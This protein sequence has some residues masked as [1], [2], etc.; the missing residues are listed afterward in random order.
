M[1]VLHMTHPSASS[2]FWSAPE[3]PPCVVAQQRLWNH[4]TYVARLLFAWTGNADQAAESDKVDVSD[5]HSAAAVAVPTSFVRLQ[6]TGVCEDGGFGTHH[7]RDALVRLGVW[8][9]ARVVDIVL[10]QA[11]CRR[12]GLSAA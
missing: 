9:H 7:F 12:P 5:D 2:V 1:A 3:S 10:V 11:L 4:L 6:Q 8:A